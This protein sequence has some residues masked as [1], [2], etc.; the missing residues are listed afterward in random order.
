M[1]KCSAHSGC[2]TV[3]GRSP[4]S[5]SPGPSLHPHPLVHLCLTLPAPHRTPS[6]PSSS[7]HYCCGASRPC[8][9]P[10]STT[11]PSSK[12]TGHGKLPVF[13]P[14]CSRAA[15]CSEGSQPW[16]LS[17]HLEEPPRA[18]SQCALACCD[19]CLCSATALLAPGRTGPPCT[20]ATPSSSSWYCFCPHWG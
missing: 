14:P 7:L 19:L 20:S 12:H 10:L 15:L 9:P 13:H 8:F 1:H 2:S 18:W 6:S 11:P 4:R 5:R 16:A 17:P 3:S